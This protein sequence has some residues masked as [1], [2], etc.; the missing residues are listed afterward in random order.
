MA[1]P[2]T[3]PD[4]GS[5]SSD[6]GVGGGANPVLEQLCGPSCASQA[7]AGCGGFD[8]DDCLRDCISLGLYLV[9]YLDCLT[10][11]EAARECEAS[12]DYACPGPDDQDQCASERDAQSA[13]MLGG[14]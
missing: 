8:E 13:C 7:S 5:V 4:V 11:F 10:E 12:I 2:G 6:G 9:Y 3:P 1:R 14:L